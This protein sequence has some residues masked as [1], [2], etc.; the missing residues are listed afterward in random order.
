[1]RRIIYHVATTLD[2]FIAHEDGSIDGFPTK[3]DHVAEYLQHLEGYD[4]VLM[5]RRTYEFGYG[6]GLEPGQPAYPHMQHYVFSSTLRFEDPHDK[7]ELIDSGGLSF[8][9]A[10]RATD[11]GDVYLCG[12]GAFAGWMLGHGLIDELLIKLNPVVFSKGIR[13][14]GDSGRQVD[15][16]LR[17]SK[18]YNS[19][20]Q[21]LRYEVLRTATPSKAV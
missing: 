21:L 18:S 20:V 16:S 14:F 7:V 2:G 3:G 12:G 5:G 17:S 9:R 1:M 19:G 15:V 10:L 6:F 11:G 8:V 13:L 4:T